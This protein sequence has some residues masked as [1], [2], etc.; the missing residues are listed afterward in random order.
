MRVL[1]AFGGFW[2]LFIIM[3][4]NDSFVGFL[5]HSLVALPF[6]GLALLGVRREGEPSIAG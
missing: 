4:N 6:F 5:M 1:L 3:S 2:W